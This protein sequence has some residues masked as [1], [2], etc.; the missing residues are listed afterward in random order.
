MFC[1]KCGTEVADDVKFCPKCGA[2]VAGDTNTST[3]SSA[4]TPAPAPTS[5]EDERMNYSEA[6][7]IEAGF[8]SKR[9]KVLIKFF[10]IIAYLEAFC[11]ASRFI[12]PD[13]DYVRQHAN[14]GLV[15]FIFTAGSALIAPIPV[16]GWI[17]G[18]FF[19]VFCTV[20]TI[21]GIVK[22]AKGQVFIMPWFFGKIRIWK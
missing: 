13:K 19:S 21:M 22:A 17:V 6:K 2:S 14:N 16:F 5:T 11:F 7:D 8:D 20:L 9:S 18:G 10:A 3:E 4:P 1:S 15:L 12:L